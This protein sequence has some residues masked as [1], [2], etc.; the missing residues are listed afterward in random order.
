MSPQLASEKVTAFYDHAPG[1]VVKSRVYPIL[2]DLLFDSSDEQSKY[3]L[4]IQNAR[5]F[6]Q[7]IG[8]DTAEDEPS[9]VA[10]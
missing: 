5:I 8:L 9:E 3:F 10:L 2:H 7:T 4:G 1:V 6:L